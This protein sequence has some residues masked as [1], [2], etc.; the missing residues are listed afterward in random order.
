MEGISLWKNW[1]R[2]WDKAI[3]CFVANVSEV[4]DTV[5]K[6][7]AEWS[8]K[9]SLGLTDFFKIP[10]DRSNCPLVHSP[11]YWLCVFMC[12]MIGTWANREESLRSFCGASRVWSVNLHLSLWSLRLRRPSGKTQHTQTWI[13]LVLAE[14]HTH[15]HTHIHSRQADWQKKNL[16]ICQCIHPPSTKHTHIHFAAQSDQGVM[17]Y[18]Q[19]QWEQGT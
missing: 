14:T 16:C 7:T 2:S 11:L 10:P 9:V 17:L 4:M 12:Q 15:T 18:S 19:C 3:W 8:D 13:R 5:W 1:G 6:G